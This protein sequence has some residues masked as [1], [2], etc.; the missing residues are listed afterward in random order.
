MSGYKHI[1]AKGKTGGNLSLIEHTKHVLA[2]TEKIADY[3][4]FTAKEKQ[5]ARTGAILHDIGKANPIFQDR[6]D[7]R[8]EPHEDP[9]RHELGSLFFL[10]LVEKEYWPQVIE[11]IVA[12]HKSIKD[13]AR[14]MGI[15]DLDDDFYPK[16]AEIH[17]GDW[18]TWSKEALDILSDLDFEVRETSREEALEAFDEALRYCKSRKLG[19]SLWKGLMI[20]ADHFASSLNEL[21]YEA[22]KN[23]FHIPDLSFYHRGDRKSK[24]YPLSLI[25]T[26]NPKKHTLVT[27]PTG[28]GKTDFL[29]RR[30]KGRVFYTLPFQASINAMHQRFLNEIENDPSKVRLLHA[31]SRLSIE[32]GK[33]EE[34]ALQDKAGASVKVLTPYQLAS[35]AFGTKGYEAI[36][37]DVKE[38]DIILDEIHTYSKYSRAIVLKVVEVLNHFDCRLHIGTATMP[39][40][41]KEHVLD[42]L[43]REEVYS[44]DLEPAELDTF[45]RHTIHKVKLED[46]LLELVRQSESNKEKLLVVINRVSRAQDFYSSLQK[47]FDHLPMMLIHSRFKRKDRATLEHRLKEEFDKGKGPCIVVSTQ[48][49]EV[50]LDIS[51][52]R[53][54]TEAAPL[55]SLIQRFGRVNRRR[56][57]EN[58][59]TLKPI[60]II[61]PPDDE[62]EALPYELDLVLKSFEELPDNAVLSERDIQELLDRIYKNLDE[63]LIDLMTAFADGNFKIRELTHQARSVLLDAMEIETTTCIT[64]SDWE[65]YKTATADIRAGFEIPVSY[66]SIAYKKLDKE[67]KIGNRPFIVPDVAYDEDKGFEISKAERINYKTFEIFG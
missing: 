53:M 59:G 46:D 13:D 14:R 50:S 31:S 56:T 55:D 60:H 65:E 17:F 47:E 4:Q 28:A 16:L 48:V 23:A 38:C 21:T 62:K 24:L 2:A 18:E 7:R 49:V 61:P 35:I 12:H 15:I 19:W 30:C 34:R 39:L 20:S 64:Q 63:K 37:V 43:G 25:D 52:D 51:F 26:N 6:L 1:R 41:L 3:L 32:K 8:I 67:S 57:E 42:L 11:M 66:K 22:L 44:V 58:K 54:I 45:N 29:L 5:V 27:A 10:P 9:Y 36:L 33:V 40:T